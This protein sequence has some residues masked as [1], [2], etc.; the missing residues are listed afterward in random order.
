MTK[1]NNQKQRFKRNKAYKLLGLVIVVVALLSYNL[2]TDPRGHSIV[3]DYPIIQ[4]SSKKSLSDTLSLP[5]S[6]K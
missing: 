3:E 6:K 4:D 5:L 1:Q 2:L